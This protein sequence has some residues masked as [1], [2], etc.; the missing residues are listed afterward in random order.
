MRLDLVVPCYNEQEVLRETFNRLSSLLAELISKK[1]IDA[2]SRIYFVDDGSTDDTWSV[3]TA[4]TTESANVAGIKLSRNCGHQNALLAG[5]F[6]SRGDAVVSIDADLQDDITI[7]EEMADRFLSGIDV[8][9]GVRKKRPSDTRFKRL[10]AEAFYRLMKILGVELVFNHADFRLLSRRSVEAL[11][12]FKE[13]NLFLRGMVPLI[14]FPSSSVYYDRAER[15]A[16]ESK[17][18]LKKMITF[19]LEGVTSFSVTPLR[20]ITV[21]GLAVFLMTLVM[22]VYIFMLKFYSGGVVPGWASTVL[23]IYLLS[24]I[25]IFCIGIIG[26]YLGKIYIETKARPRY[27]VEKEI[28]L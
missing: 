28:N 22:I 17:Y 27:F 10:T 7:I 14:G 25:Q 9:F 2:D 8:V 3:I 24:G 16:G 15:F 4:L 26:E 19:A 5:I 12:D 23:P 11:K 13:V 1:K 20:F 18:P 6:S 21:I